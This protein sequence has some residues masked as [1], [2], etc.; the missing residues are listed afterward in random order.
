MQCVAKVDF[1]R[2][3]SSTLITL[4]SG[5]PVEPFTHRP[6]VFYF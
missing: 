6:S 4:L 2:D 1:L 5:P 3:F